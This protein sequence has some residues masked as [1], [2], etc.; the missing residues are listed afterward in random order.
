MHNF[1]RVREKIRATVRRPEVIQIVF[2]RVFEACPTRTIL[3]YSWNRRRTANATLVSRVHAASQW[4]GDSCKRM[5]PK[6]DNHRS[7]LEHKDLLFQDNTVSW[8]RIVNGVDRYV[9]ELMPTTKEEN[10]ASGK[11]IA[12][13]RP[14][15]KPTVTLTSISILVQERIWIDFE[16]QRSNDKKCFE[17]WKAIT[18]LLRHDQTVPRGI[19]GA[20][21]YNDIMEECRRK[22]FDDAS[23]QIGYQNWHREEERRKRFKYCVKSKLPE[24]IPVPSSKSRTFRRKW[25]WS[26][27][28]RQFTDSERIY[29]VSSPRR[30]RE[31]IEFYNE[32]WINSRKNKPQKRKTVG[33]LHNSELDGGCRGNSVRSH[34]TKDRAIQEYLETPSKYCFLVQFEARPRERSAILPNAVTCSRSP[35]THCLQLALRKRYVW[36]LTDDDSTRRYAWLRECHESC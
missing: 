35:Q 26:C 7:S 10:T 24:S 15:Q 27:T 32:K 8:V 21:H 5:V 29:R 3:L 14:R 23:Q 33:L 6:Q 28:A 25:C 13:A 17:V 9:T 31:W 11:P 20:I 16:T 34:E 12:K 18:R 22:K 4:R 1:L 30:E 36:K 19:D 2:W